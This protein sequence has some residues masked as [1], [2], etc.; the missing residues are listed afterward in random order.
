MN[1]AISCSQ[2]IYEVPDHSTMIVWS[3]ACSCYIYHWR[4][5]FNSH[6][7][8]SF[9]WTYC[10]IWTISRKIQAINVLSIWLEYIWDLMTIYIGSFV[11]C[12]LQFMDCFLCQVCR[13]ILTWADIDT[14]ARA[15]TVIRN[16]VAELKPLRGS[17]NSKLPLSSLVNGWDTVKQLNIA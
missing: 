10:H 9:S 6:P 1:F 11:R 12:Q 4:V 3:F 5:E 16:T 13:W 8:I 2:A 7:E 14:A 15:I 17:L